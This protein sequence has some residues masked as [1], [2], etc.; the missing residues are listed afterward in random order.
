MSVRRFWEEVHHWF[1]PFEPVSLDQPQLH[2]LR[3]PRYNPIVKLERELRLTNDFC[4]FLLTGTVGNGKTSELNHCASR[5]TEHRMVVL[6]DL[7]AHVQGNVRDENA[8]DH[9]EMWELLGLIGIAIFRAA[10]A[11]FGHQWGN[12]PQRLEQAI[13]RLREA[14]Q[15]GSASEIDV[16]EL[17]RGMAVAAGGIAGAALGGPLGVTVGG[18]VK[19]VSDATK[20]TW[21]VGLPGTRRRD[22][23]DGDVRRVLNAVNALID[24][25][26]TAYNRRL[27]LVLDGLDRIRAPERTQ[28]LFLDSRLLGS[29]ACDQLITVPL[30]LMRRQ[31]QNVEH[32]TIKDL[33]NIPVL[34]REAPLNRAV[35]GPGLGFFRELVAKRIA[36]VNQK[37]AGQ[38]IAA[39][40][41]PLPEP[42]VD[43]LA[44]YS[45]GLARDFIKLVRLA[46]LE[47]L[48]KDVDQLDD[49]I[50]DQVLRE[51]REDKEYFM[52]KRE[53]ALLEAVMID[54][55]RRLPGDELALELLVQR[56]LLA[57]PNETT[58]YFPHPLLTLAL[59]KPRG[60]STG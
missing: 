36:W 32:F 43:R 12:E 49:A 48:D 40:S 44:Y 7:W 25:L 9:L 47:A 16:A 45:G 14:E 42:I 4:R 23:Q 11:R 60:G 33:H 34:A 30:M 27:L 1:N 28:A 15:V 39:P 29:V 22:D 13:A 8:L 53:I 38:G 54:P 50:V 5:L 59:L 56:R 10:E 3:D 46:A 18:L 31:G 51:A 58:W 19:T 21:K 20:W 57:F 41:D 17:G 2:A 6:V 24:G 55:D 37:L 26:Q 52:S 35:A